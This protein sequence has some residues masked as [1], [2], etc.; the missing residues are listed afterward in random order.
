MDKSYLLLTPE[1]GKGRR[2]GKIIFYV[3]ALLMISTMFLPDENGNLSIISNLVGLVFWWALI[4]LLPKYVAENKG[5]KKKKK[6]ESK[7]ND[8]PVKKEVRQKTKKKKEKRTDQQNDIITSYVL[9]LIILL[10]LWFWWVEDWLAL[11]FNFAGWGFGTG[12]KIAAFIALFFINAGW[13][14]TLMSAKRA[15]DNMAYKKK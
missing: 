8:K 14:Q 1:D 4:V 12:T 10:A 2:I 5:K 13:V 15:S 3:L 11:L 9:T 6:K 7:P